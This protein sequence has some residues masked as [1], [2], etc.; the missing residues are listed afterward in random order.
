MHLVPVCTGLRWRGIPSYLGSV[1]RARSVTPPRH[2]SRERGRPWP[3]LPGNVQGG[4]SREQEPIGYRELLDGHGQ[5]HP[6]ETAGEL[7]EGGLQLDPGKRRA[8]A[9]VRPVT[10]GQVRVGLPGDIEP[11][12]V[13]ED[14]LVVVGRPL[15]Q[16]DEV[17]GA[18]V[19]PVILISARAYRISGVPPQP[20]ARSA[21]SAAAGTRAGSA[22]SACHCSGWVSSI[23]APMPIV[24]TVVSC[25]AHSRLIASMA[26]A[27]SGTSGSRT[28]RR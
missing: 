26:T 7:A 21:S 3:S 12:R 13:V 19:L 14:G 23:S 24:Y 6:R 1:T 2:G 20:A 8:G 25:P 4:Q 22:C 15:V 28:S 18:M 17:A 9:V 16:Q 11:G 10:E 5:L 27:S